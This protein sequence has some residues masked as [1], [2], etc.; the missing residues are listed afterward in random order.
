[1]AGIK[2]KII[3]QAKKHALLFDEKNYFNKRN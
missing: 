1:M 2:D 3:E